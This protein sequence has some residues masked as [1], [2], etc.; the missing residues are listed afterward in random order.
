M[1]LLYIDESGDNGLSERSTD[2]FTLAGLAVEDRF[3]KEYSWLVLDLRRRISQRYGV[4]FAEFKASELFTHR[5][6]S[7]GTGLSYDDSLWIYEQLIG[8][9]CNPH[10]ELFMVA[11]SKQKFMARQPQAAIDKLI[12]VFTERVWREFLSAF[13]QH[14]VDQS[15]REGRPQTGLLYVDGK[16][17]K[18]V[19]RLVRE[20]AKKFDERA[21]YRG[22]GLIEDVVFRDSR[23]SYFVQ[24][25]DTLAFSMG[26]IVTGHEYVSEI[27]ISPAVADKLRAKVKGQLI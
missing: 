14:L 7:F 25:A 4:V 18:Y 27:V 1:N 5:G 12:R 15:Q 8:L 6:D 3:W 23:N 2:Y 22:A 26:R 21:P 20:Y 17:N 11:A 13:E 9:I 16:D 10:V 19:R 24:L